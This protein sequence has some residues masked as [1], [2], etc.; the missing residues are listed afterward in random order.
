MPNHLPETPGPLDR[1]ALR[2][3]ARVFETDHP[4]DEPFVLTNS[5]RRLVRL[6][7][8]G[9]MLLS[10]AL[11]CLTVLAFFLPHRFWPLLFTKTHLGYWDWPFISFLFA[12]LLLYL[13]VY[14][15]TAVHGMAIKFISLVCQFPRY[16]DP[17]YNKH[18]NT[19]GAVSLRKG[20]RAHL[21]NPPPVIPQT[22]PWHL[23]GATL[24]AL[25]TAFLASLL[26][27]WQPD[28]LPPV[29][30][31]W[32]SALAFAAW[33]GWTS[34]KILH[35]ARIRILAPLTIRQFVNELAEEYGRTPEFREW[36]PIV[37][38]HTCV[39]KANDSYPHLVLYHLLAG[40]FGP[41]PDAAEAPQLPLTDC[42]GS[43]QP[44]LERLL[45][46]S[47]IIDGRLG[48]SETATLNRLRSAG[49]LKTPLEEVRTQLSH[50]RAGQGLWV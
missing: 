2:Y 40:R 9:T 50:F 43:I 23:W 41:L 27:R 26:L 15:L 34:H 16:H 12:F 7:E 20:L 18:L 31:I 47:V 8:F 14:T 48:I 28:D 13:N 6:G 3:L 36:V 45:I 10:A 33:D 22:V 11:G 42:P 24:K 1:A 21:L 46:F 29:G 30:L 35:D 38:Q 32:P 39:G 4:S 17:D 49:W 5:E 19:V 25:A 44:G 37:L